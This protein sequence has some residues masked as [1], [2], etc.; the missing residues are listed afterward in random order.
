MTTISVPEAAGP[1][2]GKKC[3]VRV[4]AAIAALTLLPW[5]AARVGKVRTH[6]ICLVAGAAGYA[7]FF[8]IKDAN[9]LIAAEVGIGIAWAS[10][11]AM[12][13]TSA[14]AGRRAAL[15]SGPAPQCAMPAPSSA[16]MAR[17]ILS[18]SSFSSAT[19]FSISKISFLLLSQQL[20]LSD[21]F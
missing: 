14:M 16:S 11:L 17:L 5:L 4:V 7:S 13:P 1:A 19:I 6:A 15:R 3:P 2:K 12:P 10:I 18:L 8:V 9:W 20:R 21:C